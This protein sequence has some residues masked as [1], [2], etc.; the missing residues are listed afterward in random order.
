MDKNINYL[1]FPVTQNGMKLIIFYAIESLPEGFSIED[2]LELVN[3][4]Q[5]IPYVK[6]KCSPPSCEL[7]PSIE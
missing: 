2:I 5:K 4:R 6:G 1:D 7:Y 3:K